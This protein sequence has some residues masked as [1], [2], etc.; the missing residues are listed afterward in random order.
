MSASG[1]PP[2]LT[3]DVTYGL[4][5]YDPGATSVLSLSQEPNPSSHTIALQHEW[6][7]DLGPMLNNFGSSLFDSMGGTN[8]A[9]FAGLAPHDPFSSTTGV[10]QDDLLQFGAELGGKG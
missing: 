4:S 6:N 1:A 8:Q 5:D 10:Y 7:T 9:N 3:R 2:S